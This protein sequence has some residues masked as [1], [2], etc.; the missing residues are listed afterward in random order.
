MVCLK[1]LCHELG[2]CC[3]R[4]LRNDCDTL[5]TLCHYP[6]A[7]CT[8]PIIHVGSP[9]PQHTNKVL[10]N[11]CFSFLLLLPILM[12]NFFGGGGK[13]GALWDI[14]TKYSLRR[15]IIAF[16]Y[17]SCIKPLEKEFCS[18]NS[19]SKQPLSLHMHQKMLKKIATRITAT[20][21]KVP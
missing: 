5:I 7:I 11:L 16:L 18:V 9:P 10:H 1:V 4:S 19:P 21:V 3:F 20:C 8:S 12:P 13:Q 15:P 6:F 2:Y 17:L 14:Y